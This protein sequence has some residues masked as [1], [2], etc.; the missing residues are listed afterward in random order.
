MTVD[1]LEQLAR[2]SE[3]ATQG[4]WRTREQPNY[5]AIVGVG[6]GAFGV[7]IGIV[8]T[9]G[10]VRNHDDIEFIAALVNWYRS[11]GAELARAA[12]ELVPHL[13]ARWD[14]DDETADIAAGEAACDRLIKAARQVGGAAHDD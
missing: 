6:Q 5:F 3:K 2:L 1:K 7:D 9:N 13:E 11:G 14:E 4:E 10:S 8:R 12:L